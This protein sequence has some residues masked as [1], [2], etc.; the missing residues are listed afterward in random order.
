MTSAKTNPFPLFRP[1]STVQ[2]GSNDTNSEREAREVIQ[3]DQRLGN[4]LDSGCCS[5]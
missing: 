3:I 1:I 5:L 2:T 4:R